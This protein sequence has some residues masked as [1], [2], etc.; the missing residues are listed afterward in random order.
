MENILIK[1]DRSA[2]PAFRDFRSWLSR[3]QLQLVRR[4]EKLKIVT[5]FRN[6][7]IHGRRTE[8]DPETVVESC[9]SILEALNY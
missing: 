2:E 7:A 3:E 9:R 5:K 4:V 1:S 6:P 8:M